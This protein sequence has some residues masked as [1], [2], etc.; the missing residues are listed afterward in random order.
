[1]TR[2]FATVPPIAHRTAH[3]GWCAKRSK[4]VPAPAKAMRWC[5]IDGEAYPVGL[6]WTWRGHD[7]YPIESIISVH[8][9]YGT[10]LDIF[11]AHLV[12][13]TVK[14]VL[15]TAVIRARRLILNLLN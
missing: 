7:I 1:M 8:G 12:I 9:D 15:A 6:F 10:C 14:A 4:L 13:H 3:A 2:S 11:P 5:H